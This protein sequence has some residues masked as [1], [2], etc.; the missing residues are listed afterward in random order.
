MPPDLLMHACLPQVY[1]TRAQVRSEGL[2]IVLQFKATVW[3]KVASESTYLESSK[4]PKFSGEHPT[5][6][7]SASFIDHYYVT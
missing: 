3:P 5:D 7:L 6:P 2:V 4:I 1:Y